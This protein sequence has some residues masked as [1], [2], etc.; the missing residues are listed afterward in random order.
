M[1]NLSCHGYFRK[2]VN[3]QMRMADAKTRKKTTFAIISRENV[4]KHSGRMILL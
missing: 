1:M 3:I 4:K 2:R